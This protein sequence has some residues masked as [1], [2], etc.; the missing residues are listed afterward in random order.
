MDA[1]KKPTVYTYAKCSTCRNAVKWLRAEGI[2]FEEKPIRE[3]P[4]TPAELKRMLAFQVGALKRLFNTS[5]GDYREL[6]LGSKL[7]DMTEQDALPYWP[8]M[9]I[10]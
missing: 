10:W 3:S 5:G 1:V 4:P 6:K 2:D 7:P 9:A 8:R